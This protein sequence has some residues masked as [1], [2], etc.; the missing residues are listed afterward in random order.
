[1]DKM[2]ETR[3]PDSAPASA[4]SAVRCRRYRFLCLALIL[5]TLITAA[6]LRAVSFLV[7]SPLPGWTAVFI[8]ACPLTPASVLIRLLLNSSA[9]GLVIPSALSILPLVGWFLA[10]A[11]KTPGFLLI[12]ICMIA[13]LV[14][15]IPVLMFGATGPAFEFGLLIPVVLSLI[16]PQQTLRAARIWENNE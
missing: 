8:C 10:N 9:A 6:G 11:G 15:W 5:Y 7:D 1:M 14:C 3:H 13:Q 16:L 12:R 4:R 2:D